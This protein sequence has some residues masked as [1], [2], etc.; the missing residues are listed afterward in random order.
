MYFLNHDIL[1]I[2]LQRFKILDVHFSS[3]C[4]FKA[5][6][7]VLGYLE[8]I[9]KNHQIHTLKFC[10]ELTGAEAEFD[11][12]ACNLVLASARAFSPRPWDNLRIFGSHF[13]SFET[14]FKDSASQNLFQN[15][16][17]PTKASFFLGGCE[18]RPWSWSAVFVTGSSRV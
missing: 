8:E 13:L 5:M 15:I 10:L 18:A 16:H 3:F 9:K 1:L 4:F 14:N 17:L 7:T 2:A 6:K 11:E 12:A